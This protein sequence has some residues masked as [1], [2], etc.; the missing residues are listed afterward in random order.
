MIRLLLAALLSAFAMTPAAAGSDCL[1]RALFDRPGESEQPV[2]ALGEAAGQPH[3]CAFRSAL[4]R[5]ILGCWRIDPTSGRLSPPLARVLAGTAERVVPDA[6]GCAAGYCASVA[7]DPEQRWMLATSTAGTHVALLAGTHV[8]VFEAATR[9]RTASIRL[10]DTS[11]P[12]HTV[13]GNAPVNL[14]FAGATLLVVGS[15]AGP[16]IGV[17]AFDIAG[18]RLGRLTRPGAPAGSAFNI[19][20]GGISILDAHHVALADAGLQHLL[21]LPVGPGSARMVKRSVSQT[22]CRLRHMESMA[23]GDLDQPRACRETLR[24][25][26]EPYFEA[27]PWRRGDGDVLVALNGPALGELATLDGRNLAEKSRIALRRCP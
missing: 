18:R 1:P 16:F 21:I 4:D 2:L 13:V 24:L 8:D 27:T 6:N 25:R 15:D 10:F 19:T 17:W 22:P 20:Y 14:L 11:A 26:F 12:E 5:H 7:P 23:L 3:L 9:R